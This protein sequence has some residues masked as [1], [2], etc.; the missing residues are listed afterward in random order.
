[1]ATKARKRYFYIDENTSSE[2]IYAFLDDVDNDDKD[3]I[4][5]L[6]NDSVTKFKAEEKIA[7]AASTQNT[8]LT[9]RSTK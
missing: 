7:L 2:Q 8:S 5:N 1:M 4:D 3:E 9:S 6:M